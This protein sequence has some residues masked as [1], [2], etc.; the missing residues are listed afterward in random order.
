MTILY[1]VNAWI[2]L[3]RRCSQRGHKSNDSIDEQDERHQKANWHWNP[4]QHKAQSSKRREVACES[5]R[6]PSGKNTEQS[7]K[8]KTR[9]QASIPSKL[10]DP[11]SF[12]I[13]IEI[14]DIYFSKL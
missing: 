13:P 4:K 8:I 7:R 10:K 11:G 12:R 3:R 6:S 9:E 14:G 2:G 5:N 1:V